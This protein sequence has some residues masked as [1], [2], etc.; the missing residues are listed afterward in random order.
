MKG[1]FILLLLVALSACTSK[2][3]FVAPPLLAKPEII[4]G[5]GSLVIAQWRQIQVAASYV[6]N[7]ALNI[8]NQSVLRPNQIKTIKDK[9][10][11]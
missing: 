8:E 7:A 4:S 1:T 10:Y 11:S 6:G 3:M 5:D 9:V 2:S